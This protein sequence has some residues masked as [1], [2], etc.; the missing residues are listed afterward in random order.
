[1]DVELISAVSNRAVA[2]RVLLHANRSQAQLLFEP[3]DG[4]G[5][6]HLYFFPHQFEYQATD[7]SVK[8]DRLQTALLAGLRPYTDA[9]FQYAAE[10][11]PYSTAGVDA[12]WLSDAKAS[13]ARLPKCEVVAWQ[14]RT[15]FDQFTE[16]E[17][18]ATPAEVT[19]LLAGAHG[20]LLFPGKSRWPAAGNRRLNGG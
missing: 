19:A 11:L 20:L 18:A 12:R 2:N 7:S 14:A 5:T 3:I 9:L 4:P 8:R 15:R 10:L 6:Y 1:M 16:M 13:A 17:N